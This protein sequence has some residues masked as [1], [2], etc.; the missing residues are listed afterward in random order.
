MITSRRGTTMKPI[1]YL[2]SIPVTFFCILVFVA[3]IT[4][5]ADHS[6]IAGS[7]TDTNGAAIVGAVVTLTNDR[8]GE[9]RTLNSAGDG[10]F[11]FVALKPDTY[12]IRVTAANF[13]TST[14]AGVQL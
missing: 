2:R 3:G 14:R 7:V 10:T 4:A 13:E 12:S 1:S 6:R 5:Q 9:T 8:T 11:R